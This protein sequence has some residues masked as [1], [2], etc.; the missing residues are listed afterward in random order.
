MNIMEK[1]AFIPPSARERAEIQSL[2]ET[3]T[4]ENTDLATLKTAK[5]ALHKNLA[6]TFQLWR[7]KE[8][9]TGTNALIT[10]TKTST[11]P[12]RTVELIR[13]LSTMSYYFD[14][15]EAFILAT[16]DLIL[17]LL[18]H[19]HGHVRDAA[20][21]LIGNWRL[22][23]GGVFE[24]PTNY[25]TLLIKDLVSLI[26]THTPA[27]TSIPIEQMTPSIYK[28]LLL[29]YEEIACGMYIEEWITSNP[30]Y[31]IDIPY[32]DTPLVADRAA[33][34]PILWRGAPCLPSTLEKSAM[35][36]EK[37]YERLLRF[38]IQAG[39]SAGEVNDT[40][41][42]LAIATDNQ[43]EIGVVEHI[44]KL[45]TR[46]KIDPDTLAPIIRE[47]QSY[48]N[49]KVR[50]AR[51][52]DFNYI[53]LSAQTE[54]IEQQIKGKVNWN[55]WYAHVVA[56]HEAIDEFSV[57]QSKS[58]RKQC[59][60][61]NERIKKIDSPDVA[62]YLS[63]VDEDVAEHEV[64]LLDVCSVAH[65]VWSWLVQSYPTLPVKTPQKHAAICYSVVR[66]I[67]QGMTPYTT[68]HLGSF[69]G[70]KSPGS[71]LD[72]ARTYV[73]MLLE[74][75]TEP[76]L[77]ILN[78]TSEIANEDTVQG[79]GLGNY[80]DDEA[81]ADTAIMS[82]LGEVAP[83]YLR[84]FVVL[85]ATKIISEEEHARLRRA[86]ES[87]AS[88]N[89]CR[90]EKLTMQYDFAMLIIGINHDTNPQSVIDNIIITANQPTPF[91]RFHSLIT[92]TH[93]PHPFEIEKYLRSFL[94]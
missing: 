77:F 34:L 16:K 39:F 4:N 71:S 5:I 63:D 33:L 21:R 46:N 65:Y 88:T 11:D 50:H 74:V 38:L 62:D 13:T 73:R 94:V 12:K 52:V 66:E 8:H 69:G 92:N 25:P 42:R 53:I 81:F 83:G 79:T 27:D 10:A 75:I 14:A 15:P 23:M 70:W 59:E 18:T 82:P 6:K 80:Q 76:S 36:S 89:S 41:S 61:F 35:L 19:P 58:Y 48:T 72:S 93:V 84:Y 54:R 40:R 28:S 49:H 17:K 44:I 43:G 47:M 60:E 87:E 26:R 78:G 57:E 56:V 29:A 3:L 55:E 22:C 64:Q 32:E 85:P 90:I 68:A 37:A 1:P 45:A 31:H 67:N 51:G 9:V 20:K 2:Y 24:P 91:L 30:Q 86:C 7:I